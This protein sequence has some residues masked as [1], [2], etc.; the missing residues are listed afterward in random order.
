MQKHNQSHGQHAYTNNAYANIYICAISA[1][2]D[3]NDIIPTR[4]CRSLL[5]KINVNMH[6]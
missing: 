1:T 3:T 2:N 6:V 5:S 4:I